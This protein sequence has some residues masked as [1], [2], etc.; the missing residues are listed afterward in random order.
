MQLLGTRGT[1]RVFVS[2]LMLIPVLFVISIFAFA[3]SLL[4][5]G[6]PAYA[7]LGDAATPEAVAAVR[8]ELGLDEPV[9][10]RYLTW[11]GDVVQGD[12]GSSLFG[13]T[14]VAD[15]ILARLPVTVALVGFAIV[16]TVLIAVPLGIVAAYRRSRSLDRIA[17]ALVSVG[18]AMPPFWLG[19]VLVAVVGLGL[20]WL[21]PF[22]Y[23]PASEGVGEHLSHLVLPVVALS[24]P[25]ICELFLQTRS[26]AAEVF[27]EDYVRTARAAGLSTW[28]IL[29]KWGAK[30][31]M[32]P[33]VTVTGLQLDRLVGV[34]ALVEA[35]FGMQGLG[36]LAVTAALNSDIPTIQGVILVIGAFVLV[37]NLLVDLSYGYFNPKLRT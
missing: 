36:S 26:A 20:G 12:L 35:V 15:A 7:V 11:L 24:V 18:Q 9:V 10:V 31:A 27:S 25:G 6:D 17:D 32:L 1:R 22:G 30:N 34:A 2:V 13:G 4:V 21:P 37:V 29:T 3:L 8:A 23:V 19:L 5:P 16:L 14:P 28:S 33:V